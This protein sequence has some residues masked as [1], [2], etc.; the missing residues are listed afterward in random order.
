MNVHHRSSL[1]NFPDISYSL[2]AH[3]KAR[4]LIC[5]ID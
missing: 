3:A 4:L 1:K 5:Q 2:T